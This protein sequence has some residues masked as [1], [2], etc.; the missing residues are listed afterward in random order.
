MSR[1]GKKPV[2]IP[3]GVMVKLE[4][5]ILTC[6][7]PKGSVSKQLPEKSSVNIISSLYFM[8][9]PLYGSGFL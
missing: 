5:K 7:G 4:D 3:A 6:T 9:L 1:I 8:P 2:N